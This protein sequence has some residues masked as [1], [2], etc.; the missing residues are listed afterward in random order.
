[1]QK[2]DVFETLKKWKSLVENDTNERL[3]YL[4]NDNG[5]EYCRKKFEDY[6]SSNGIH[7]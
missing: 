5:G 2:F 3:K 7:R 1:M 6:F 4:K